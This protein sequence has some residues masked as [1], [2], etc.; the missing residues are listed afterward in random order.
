MEP[1]KKAMPDMGVLGGVSSCS[2]SA[3]LHKPATRH[4]HPTLPHAISRDVLESACR[5]TYPS[6]RMKMVETWTDMLG[7][8]RTCAYTHTSQC[9]LATIVHTCDMHA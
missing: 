5:H 2:S 1:E 3:S 8:G 7:K 6:S 9:T 4:A